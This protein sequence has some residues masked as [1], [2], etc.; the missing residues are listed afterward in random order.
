VADPDQLRA[1]RVKATMKASLLIEDFEGDWEKEW[2]AYKPEKWELKTHKVYCDRWE[3]P[4]HARLVFEVRCAEENKLVVGIDK[5]AREVE[6]KGGNKWQQFVLSA[7]DFKN[8]KGEELEDWSG[9]ME[10][11][12]SATESFTLNADGEFEKTILG[13]S[14]KGE[15][16]ELRNLKWIE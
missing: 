2:F 7:G 15:M 16:P 4:E 12:F 11:R 14:W 10:F 13:A 8:A 6:L 5:Y 1:A 3:A 9:I